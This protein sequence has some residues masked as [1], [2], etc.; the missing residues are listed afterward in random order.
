MNNDYVIAVNENGEPFIAHASKK[1]KPHFITN[2][3]YF[4]KVKL[5]NGKT[6]YFYTEKAY[7]TW[8]ENQDSTKKEERDK[9]KRTRIYALQKTYISTVKKLGP[10][11][12]EAQ[13]ILKKIE[14]LKND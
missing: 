7:R 6:R 3:L 5:P 4:Q 13:G 2:Y 8:L 9:Q 1:R 12:K 10:K 11:S 14:A